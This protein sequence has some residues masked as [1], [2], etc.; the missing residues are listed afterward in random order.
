MADT[1]ELETGETSVHLNEDF[2]I[3]YI[4]AE[5]F[6]KRTEPFGKMSISDSGM[7]V[8]TITEEPHLLA[9]YS[10]LRSPLVWNIRDDDHGNGIIEVCNE[11]EMKMKSDRGIAKVKSLAEGSMTWSTKDLNVECIK[12]RECQERIK[13]CREKIAEIKL[14]TKANESSTSEL[15]G[16][17]WELV[18]EDDEPEVI[19]EESDESD[20]EDVIIT[21]TSSSMIISHTRPDQYFSFD[22]KKALK[23]LELPKEGSYNP[24][25]IRTWQRFNP[26][27]YS[28]LQL[29]DYVVSADTIVE[30][31]DP[32][33]IPFLIK[34][35]PGQET[36]WILQLISNIVRG[37]FSSVM[38]PMLKYRTFFMDK[39]R[40]AKLY[41]DNIPTD[42][43]EIV[44]KDYQGHWMLFTAKFLPGV[45]LD[46]DFLDDLKRYLRSELS[47]I[48][49]TQHL[50]KH[51]NF[52]HLPSNNDEKKQTCHAISLYTSDFQNF[53]QMVHFVTD[54]VTYNQE[55]AFED[56]PAG[57]IKF[58]VIKYKQEKNVRICTFEP[59]HP[60][61]KQI[62]NKVLENP[63]ARGD[64]SA[65]MLGIMRGIF[66]VIQ[67]PIISLFSFRQQF[68]KRVFIGGCIG[69]GK[70]TQLRAL[71]NKRL[72]FNSEMSIGSLG[73]NTQLTDQPAEITSDSFG[74]QFI[75]NQLTELYA[76]GSAE[77]EKL[78]EIELIF[79]LIEAAN[80]IMLLFQSRI[81]IGQFLD[82]FDKIRT[83]FLDFFTHSLEKMSP[84]FDFSS[85]CEK[86][87]T[88]FEKVKTYL[89]ENFDDLKTPT[90]MICKRSL[91][92][93]L[94]RNKNLFMDRSFPDIAI[95]ILADVF[96]K[97]VM[98]YQDGLYALIALKW[99]VN[100]FGMNEALFC[101]FS[102]E[103]IREKQLSVAEHRVKLR[104][105]PEEVST[106]E[107]G[108]RY[109]QPYVQG[110]NEALLDLYDTFHV[111][112]CSDLIK[113]NE[114]LHK[115]ER[116]KL[117]TVDD[118]LNSIFTSLY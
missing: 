12:V 78:M 103:S 13:L 4:R 28:E 11:P 14:K 97:R 53:D 65:I 85:L 90:K 24:K 43:K 18:C 94:R 39:T 109:V 60:L 80:L 26:N 86:F 54:G 75:M 34:N 32:K 117:P 63:E 87:Q 44:F 17:M 23:S 51:Y 50:P 35:L 56:V 31:S 57:L 102:D 38:F 105:R 116:I 59:R 3:E 77:S 68:K 47:R 106:N 91:L 33:I 73:L 76:T 101:Y 27:F 36:K 8:L 61:V 22:I 108:A 45:S 20:E 40:L 88:A 66:Q 67:I 82:A 111:P 7:E 48:F 72:V 83:D 6:D 89:Q 52:L 62:I 10:K 74:L 114:D 21:E 99:F 110:I 2:T 79:M 16:E 29:I 19:E 30:F 93:Q 118:L 37:C 64:D 100:Y 41:K 104:G 84:Y 9:G 1:T 92:E 112:L 55:E 46:Y 69:A 58:S 95:F 42:M 98:N 15:R 96:Y 71:T 70:S 25:F 81:C 113:L 115:D 107:D 49:S 5:P